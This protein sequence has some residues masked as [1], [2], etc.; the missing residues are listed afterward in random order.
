MVK[1]RALHVPNSA[2]DGSAV[3]LADYSSV[4]ARELAVKLLTEAALKCLSADSARAHGP[5]YARG[6]IC[7]FHRTPRRF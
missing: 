3:E 7:K 6:E 2:A 5:E 1:L 4:S